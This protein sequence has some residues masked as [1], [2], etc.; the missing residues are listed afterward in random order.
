[1]YLD[2][3]RLYYFSYLF[4]S[5]RCSL[6]VS[7]VAFRSHV[8]YFDRRQGLSQ[9]AD[10]IFY[11]FVK[12]R[13]CMDIGFRY[14]GS[15]FFSGLAHVMVLLRKEIEKGLRFFSAMLAD[16][17]FCFSRLGIRDIIE[18]IEKTTEYIGYGIASIFSFFFAPYSTE[19]TES[20]PEEKT[21]YFG[22]L[23]VSWRSCWR[24]K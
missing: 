9:T 4:F 20:D 7:L 17:I 3:E 23:I 13:L 18:P 24:R 12:F 10:G 22:K 21:R 6:C 1:M 8:P 16:D 5:G 2:D 19:S 14:Y 11:E 15:L